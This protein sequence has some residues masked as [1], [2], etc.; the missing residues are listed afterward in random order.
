MLGGAGLLIA[1]SIALI[2][3]AL[4]Q[5]ISYFYSPVEIRDGKADL[6]RR[7]RLGGLVADGSVRQGNDIET[8]FDVT[9]GAATISVS[10]IGILPD[11]FREGQGVIAQGNIQPDGHFKADTILAKHDENYKPKELQE[12][13]EKAGHPSEQ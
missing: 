2:M 3:S 6:T 8:I 12:A 10:Y 7:I 9:D 1:S 4:S 5:N 11:L 13:L